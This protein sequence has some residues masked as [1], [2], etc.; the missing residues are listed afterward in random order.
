MQGNKRPLPPCKA[1]MRD[2]FIAFG[3]QNQRGVKIPALFGANQRGGRA[4]P[5]QLGGQARKV[6]G[7]AQRGRVFAGGVVAE[8]LRGVA[9][10]HAPAF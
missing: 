10:K 1:I 6:A 4:K 7:L 9:A 3:L 2:G 8:G 5:P